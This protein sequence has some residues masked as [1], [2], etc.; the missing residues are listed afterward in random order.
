MQTCGPVDYR[1]ACMLLKLL[2]NSLVLLKVLKN[3]LDLI[4]FLRSKLF[5]Y[6]QFLREDNSQCKIY[7]G[8]DLLFFKESHTKNIPLMLSFDP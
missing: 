3:S 5:I 4:Y 6:N 2:K 7:L 8:N 1:G